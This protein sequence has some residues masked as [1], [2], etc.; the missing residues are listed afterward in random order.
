VKPRHKESHK[1]AAQD[2]EKEGG[3]WNKRN[4]GSKYGDDGSHTGDNIED[5]A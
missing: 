5:A 1:R 2:A 3:K 4:S